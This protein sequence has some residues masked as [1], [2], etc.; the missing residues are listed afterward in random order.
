MEK[1]DVF[2][3]PNAKFLPNK[4]VTDRLSLLDGND[5]IEIYYFGRGHTDGDLVVVFPEKRLAHFGDLFPGQGS[6][7]HRRRRTAAAASR[8]RRR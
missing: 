5:R 1:M 8:F 6:A 4:V 3:G 2:S 7:G